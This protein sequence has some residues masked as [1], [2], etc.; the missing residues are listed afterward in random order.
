MGRWRHALTSAM[1]LMRAETSSGERVEAVG[2]RQT[3]NRLVNSR[4]R[5]S[6]TVAAVTQQREG[7]AVTQLLTALKGTSGTSQVSGRRIYSQSSFPA[8]TPSRHVQFVWEAAQKTSEGETRLFPFRWTTQ[9][10]VL[11]FI[12]FSVRAPLLTWCTLSCAGRLRNCK[13]RSHWRTADMDY[14]YY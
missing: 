4:V 2:R 5:M 8:P 10:S 11:S 1:S 7:A 12:T 14:N 3:A 6:L 9:P 13:T